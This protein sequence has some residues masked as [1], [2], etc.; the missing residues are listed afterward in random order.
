MGEV[1]FISGGISVDDRGQLIYAND[2]QLD[3]YK[4]FY[5]VSNH[6]AEFVRAW[7][8]H[9]YESKAVFVMS[10]SAVVAAVKVDH[11][12]SPSRDLPVTRQILSSKRPGVL[13]IPAGYANGFMTLEAGTVVCFFSSSTLEASMG[14][15]IRFPADYWNAW[16][17]EER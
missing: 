12:E 9:R 4:R 1:E 2:F 5:A 10:G 8:G 3:G 14:D 17:V 7:H 16:Q 6:R 13:L 11:W 15:D